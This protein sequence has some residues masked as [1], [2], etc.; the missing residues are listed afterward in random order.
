M[1][2]H[3]VPTAAGNMHL[4]F[5]NI[6]EMTNGFCGG[7][8][9]KTIDGDTSHGL[10]RPQEKPA[11]AVPSRFLRKPSLSVYDLPG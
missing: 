7:K 11:R 5:V 10:H 2:A 3:S 1:P 8:E 4:W 6:R 9:S